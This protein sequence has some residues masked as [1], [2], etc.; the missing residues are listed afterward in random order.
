[1]D[2]KP[3]SPDARFAWFF[4]R[5]ESLVPVK[6]VQAEARPTSPFGT[7]AALRRT[8]RWADAEPRKVEWQLMADEDD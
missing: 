3:P 5:A 2:D 8:R 7:H 4:R 1:L 6:V